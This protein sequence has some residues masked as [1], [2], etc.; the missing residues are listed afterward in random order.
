VEKRTQ[1]IEK[2]SQQA[3]VEGKLFSCGLVF[4]RGGRTLDINDLS[5]SFGVRTVISDC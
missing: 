5:D 4:N 1:C 3:V 2:R